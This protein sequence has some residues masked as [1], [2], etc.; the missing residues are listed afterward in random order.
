V[1]DP[2]TVSKAAGIQIKAFQSPLEEEIP[3]LEALFQ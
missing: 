2:A 1:E 3:S